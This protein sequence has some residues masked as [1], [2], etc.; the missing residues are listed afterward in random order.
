VN[1]TTFTLADIVEPTNS[2]CRGTGSAAAIQAYLR[3][4]YSALSHAVVDYWMPKM[5]GAE[6]K[7]VVFFLRA[8]V[9]DR[10]RRLHADMSLSVSLDE[11][12]RQTGLDRES[13][14]KA[15]RDLERRQI[16]SA[17]R[18]HRQ[19]SVYILDLAALLNPWVG[20]TDPGLNSRVGKADSTT[21]LGS[22]IPTQS[23]VLAS[24]KPTQ[25]GTFKSGKPTP[26]KEIK[27]AAAAAFAI[28]PPGETKSLTP[29]ELAEIR[30]IAESTKIQI[31]GKD[32]LRLKAGVDQ[33]NLTLAHLRWFLA[34]EKFAGARSPRAV[35]LTI[36]KEFRE[37]AQ[38]II[39]PD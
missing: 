15:I 23:G 3:H 5:S 33:A 32:A 36:A 10:D 18:S 38:G 27:K 39:W 16:I 31:D 25:N 24:G 28:S 6:F 19:T 37:R 29:E 20:K 22:G 1:A 26:Y 8:T 13:A 4:G 7:L 30:R 9:G 2:G 17:I 12:T 21:R 11:I 14:V 34:D 35:L